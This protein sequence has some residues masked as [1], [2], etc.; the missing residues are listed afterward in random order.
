MGAAQV[1]TNV[2]MPP[3]DGTPCHP[4]ACRGGLAG[5]TP[6]CPDANGPERRGIEIRTNK[7]YWKK[8][9]STLAELLAQKAEL[10]VKIIQ[11]QNAARAEAVTN[12]RKI[13]SEFKLTIEE[14]QY[15]SKPPRPK[16]R[17]SIKYKDPETGSTWTGRGIRPN[18]LTAALANGKSLEQYSVAKK[19]KK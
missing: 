15:G 10:E 14:I 16:T 17:V 19:D 8:Y 7:S 9:M 2:G 18:W 1:P 4:R 3:Q 6:A 11:A 12:V 13:I 5:P